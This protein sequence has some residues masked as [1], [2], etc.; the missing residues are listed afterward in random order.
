M[1]ARAARD[2]PVFAVISA[3][4]EPVAVTCCREGAGCAPGGARCLTHGLWDALGGAIERFLSGVTLADVVEGRFDA[5]ASA[6]AEAA[7]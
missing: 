7:A 6:L 2:I 1:L 5:P 3:V 4:D